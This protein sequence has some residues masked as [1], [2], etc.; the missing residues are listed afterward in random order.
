MQGGRTA[1]EL[2][3]SGKPY[4]QKELLDSKVISVF[5]TIL[6]MGDGF[7]GLNTIGGRTNGI[8]PWLLMVT[9]ILYC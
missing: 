3:N 1:Q 9:G 2:K 7:A 4:E 6:S 8:T 5:Y